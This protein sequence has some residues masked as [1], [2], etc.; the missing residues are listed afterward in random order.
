MCAGLR[1][2]SVDENFDLQGAEQDPPKDSELPLADQ[3]LW[4]RRPQGHFRPH[5]L[6]R[7]MHTAGELPFDLVPYE[8]LQWGEWI[9]EI[10]RLTR[11]SA[12]I[13][14][15]NRPDAPSAPSSGAPPDGDSHRRHR[16]RR[17]SVDGIL[18]FRAGIYKGVLG[19]REVRGL[20]RRGGHHKLSWLA[21]GG[22]DHFEIDGPGNEFITEIAIATAGPQKAIKV[23]VDRSHLPLT[24]PLPVRL[25]SMSLV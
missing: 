17:S 3:I 8:P 25:L 9:K 6:P 20:H 10:Y 12:R 22:D 1:P 19:A 18:G 5:P 14:Y 2:H 11:I 24:V 4:S 23:S 7:V 21:R 15:K 16:R 13:L